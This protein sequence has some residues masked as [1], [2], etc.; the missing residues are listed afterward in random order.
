ML[1]IDSD[2]CCHLSDKIDL[3]LNTIVS[4]SSWNIS[5]PL[6]SLLSSLITEPLVASFRQNSLILPLNIHESKHH[7]LLYADDILSHSSDLQ[8]SISPSSV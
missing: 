4:G 1:L 2:F 5:Y 6:S 7:F 3:H 8:A